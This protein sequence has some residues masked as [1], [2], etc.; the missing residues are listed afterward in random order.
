MSYNVIMG[1]NPG[2]KGPM[3]LT[4]IV[5]LLYLYFQLATASKYSFFYMYILICGLWGT[6]VQ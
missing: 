4:L 1:Q 6:Y 5:I 3:Y 2:D